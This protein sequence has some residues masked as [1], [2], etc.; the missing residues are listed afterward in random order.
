M[1]VRSVIC[2]FFYPC[3]RFSCV[4]SLGQLGQ[5]R[6]GRWLT[7]DGHLGLTAGGWTSKVKAPADVVLGQGSPTSPSSQLP[8]AYCV[9]E[10]T[11]ELLGVSFIRTLI[12]FL[13][14]PPHD[15][16]T[17]KPRPWHHSTWEFWG[18]TDT[19][20]RAPCSCLLLLHQADMNLG[21]FSLSPVVGRQLPRNQL[22]HTQ[23]LETRAHRLP[24]LPR[25]PGDQACSPGSS[26]GPGLRTGIVCFQAPVSAPLPPLG[27]TPPST[28]PKSRSV[29][30]REQHLC[31]VSRPSLAEWAPQKW[32]HRHTVC[33]SPREWTAR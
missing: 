20:S 31:G 32:N 4:L 2:Y 28:I 19:Q 30:T 27:G 16:V 3:S 8:P 12:T 18:D 26:Q 14:A 23:R 33:S 22:R 9:A 17:P 7:K 5:K 25:Q 1:R 13:R 21:L 24:A 29:G 11:G 6:T 10:G 15:L